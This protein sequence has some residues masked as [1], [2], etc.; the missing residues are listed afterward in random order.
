MNIIMCMYGGP[1][2]SDGSG[3]RVIELRSGESSGAV[4]PLDNG[5][6]IAH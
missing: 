6:T 1:T 2:S 5:V 3:S 4:E